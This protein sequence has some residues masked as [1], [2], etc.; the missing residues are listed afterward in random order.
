MGRGMCTLA[1]DVIL[2]MYSMYHTKRCWDGSFSPGRRFFLLVY[3][4]YM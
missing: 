1:R 4:T 3:C 2:S